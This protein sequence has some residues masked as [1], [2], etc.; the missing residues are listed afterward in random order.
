MA[1]RGKYRTVDFYRD[2]KTNREIHGLKRRPDGRFYAAVH[3]TKTFGK[4]PRKAIKRFRAWE[5]SRT[6]ATIPV[7]AR[8]QPILDHAKTRTDRGKVLL[9]V[10][11]WPLDHVFVGADEA[12]FWHTVAR[13]IRQSPKLVAEKTGIEEIGYLTELKPP[14][15]AM[16]LKDVVRYY[17]SKNQT[18]QKERQT[19][20]KA[21]ADFLKIIRQVNEA[22]TVRDV[23]QAH[24]N[25]FNG[26]I[27][28]LLAKGKLEPVTAKHKMNMIKTI[29]N[30]AIKKSDESDKPD[31]RRIRDLC[32]SF[33]PPTTNGNGTSKGNGKIITPADYHK[34]LKAAH[35]AS[36]Y[37]DK[38]DPEL[39]EPL[40]LI[41]LNCCFTGVSLR[42][43]KPEHVDL[44]KKT[45]VFPRPK[46]A[47]VR[48][49]VL[50]DRTVKAIRRYQEKRPH[51]LEYLFANAGSKLNETTLCRQFQKIASKAKV[52]ATHKM[53]RSSGFTAAVD[54]GCDPLHAEILMGHRSK[55]SNVTDA[56]LE[57]NPQHVADATAA[58]EKVYFSQ[59]KMDNIRSWTTPRS[60]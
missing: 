18:S 13:L 36:L 26:H 57:R 32:G 33:D 3:P 50:W 55:L 1:K 30:F 41:S 17:E 2:P 25:H 43:L 14:R 8:L 56:Y 49:G 45:L 23:K 44:R 12:A 37:V 58:I 35:N 52:K 5:A 47:I 59:E 7:L 38:I 19:G 21:W 4:D 22:E 51:G 10:G 15:P 29:L 6:K 53:L 28:T 9:A 27:H 42:E 48:V 40:L 46:N 60:M 39:W 31:L 20:S 11:G 54:G 24:I 16:R 34:L